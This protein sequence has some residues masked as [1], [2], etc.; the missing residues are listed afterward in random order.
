MISKSN[1]TSKFAELVSE[2]EDLVAILNSTIA[3]YTLFVPTNHAFDKFKKPPK[4][5]KPPKELIKKFLTY[6]IS[7]DAYPVFKLLLGHTIPSSLDGGDLGGAQRIRVGLGPGGLT[8]NFYSRVVAGNIFATNGVIHAVDAVL[9]PPPTVGQIIKFF[10]SEFSTFLL[11]VHV[12]NVTQ[13]I[14]HVHTG[15]T[16]FAPPNAA[17]K[18]LGPKIN[19]FL[20]SPWGRK[21]LK[22]LIK[23]HIVVNETLYSD[24]YYHPGSKSEVEVKDI[25]KGNYHVDLPTLLE[26][27]HLSIDIRRFGGLIAIIINSQSSVE[28]QDIVAKDGVIQVVKNVLIPPK[29]PPTGD[30]TVQ[31]LKEHHDA[32]DIENTMGMTVKQFCE[33]FEGLVEDDGVTGEYVEEDVL[34]VWE[35]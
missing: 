22:A 32:E 9:F 20:F 19:A 8:V 13:E 24:A 11:A 25:P 29:K 35:H 34:A 14:P 5:F 27:K 7:H 6:H 2:H 15:G 17:F 26:G 16:L 4:D 10:P 1:F 30:L 23:Y 3:N 31:E 33:R 12:T 21:Y 28:I 18:K